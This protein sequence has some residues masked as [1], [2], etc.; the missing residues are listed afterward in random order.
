MPTTIKFSLHDAQKAILKKRSKRNALRCGRK[1]GK[2]KITRRILIGG[3]QVKQFWA[4]VAPEYSYLLEWQEAFMRTY[5]DKRT[6][7]VEYFNKQDK[8]MRMH[9]GAILDMGSLDDYADNL[10]PR[11]YD[12][13]IVDEVSYSAHSEEAWEKALSPTLAARDGEAWMMS[14]PATKKGGPFFKRICQSKY[15]TESH[16][17]T[18]DNPNIPRAWIEQ[19]KLEMPTAVFE[20]EILALFISLAGKRV[21]RE[22]LENRAHHPKQCEGWTY[23]LGVDPAVSLKTE[24]DFTALVVTGRN[25]KFDYVVADA[26]R[27]KWSL[28]TMVS[29][30]NSLGTRWGVDSINVENVQAQQWLVEKL[31]AE[32]NHTINGVNP[33][34]MGDKLARFIGACEGKLEHGRMKL[35]EHIGDDFVDELLDFPPEGSDHDDFVDALTYS[36]HGHESGIIVYNI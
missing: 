27:G 23:S 34:G 18:Y 12:G 15:W 7:L 31:I 9:T 5:G 21:K 36:T 28:D 17:T 14:T 13:L 2:T 6:G 1:F 8:R 19:Q 20:Q 32:T 35:A 33:S 16:Y 3:F 30:I 4:Y 11:E 10:R 22:W 29:Q 26:I 25:D 24:N